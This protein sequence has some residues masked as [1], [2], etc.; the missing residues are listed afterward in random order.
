MLSP[1]KEALSSTIMI[2]SGHVATYSVLVTKDPLR[3]IYKRAVRHRY[4]ILPSSAADA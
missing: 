2:S 3:Q 1:V 4:W